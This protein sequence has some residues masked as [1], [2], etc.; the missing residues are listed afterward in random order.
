M[1]SNHSAT[2]TKYRDGW[3]AQKWRLLKIKNMQLFRTK[4]HTGLGYLAYHVIWV[5]L[6]WL[7]KDPKNKTTPILYNAKI[8]LPKATL[9]ILKQLIERSLARQK[10][11]GAKLSNICLRCH[12][13]LGLHI[14]FGD[15]D[16]I[17]LPSL[18]TKGPEVVLERGAER[19]MGYM[20][21]IGSFD[22]GN[23]G[24]WD[25]RFGQ[26]MLVVWT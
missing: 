24:I 9:A 13:S 26:G 2:Y 10:A 25:H 1:G 15:L 16:L 23:W 3:A 11:R 18:E 17:I 7:A 4:C 14:F 12:E 19:T 20:V 21:L 22:Y 6:F 8:G 5:S